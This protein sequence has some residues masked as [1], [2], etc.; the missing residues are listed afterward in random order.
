M[1]Q[2]VCSCCEKLLNYELL[3]KYHL[4]KVNFHWAMQFTYSLSHSV[5]VVVETISKCHT[6]GPTR[7]QIHDA[8]SS[9]TSTISCT[10]WLEITCA[11]PCESITS[12]SLYQNTHCIIYIISDVTDPTVCVWPITEML[13]LV[14]VWY[15]WTSNVKPLCSKFHHLCA[16]NTEKLEFNGVW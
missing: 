15:V 1:W 7:A 11:I 4:L 9:R 12:Q 16:V 13:Q 14:G 3:L 5:Y 8:E 6:S 2:N 10:M